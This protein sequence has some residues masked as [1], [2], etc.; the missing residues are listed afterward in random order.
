MGGNNRYVHVDDGLT[1][2]TFFFDVTGVVSFGKGVVG[3]IR[4]SH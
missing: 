3:A 4:L 1:T 2:P